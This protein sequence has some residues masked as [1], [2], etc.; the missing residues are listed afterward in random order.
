MHYFVNGGGG[1]YLSI[2]T[3]FDWPAQST[4][5]Q[6]WAFYPRLDDL[7][8]KLDSETPLWKRPFLFWLEHF[9]AW[10]ISTTEPL[11]GIFDFNRAPYFQSFVEVR[12]ERS[13]HRARLILHGTTG[14]LHWRD[15][16]LG[17]GLHPADTKP[18]DR[19]EFVIPMV[20]Q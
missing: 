17:G 7:T 3:A 11:S 2:G 5:V 16:Q 4:T 14:P 15:L 12:V 6:S 1:A 8:R 20:S 9:G 13:A 10:P 18:D 19:V